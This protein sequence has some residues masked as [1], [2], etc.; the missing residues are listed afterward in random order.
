[1]KSYNTTE[2]A[3]FMRLTKYCQRNGRLGCTVL[4]RTEETSN[5]HTEQDLCGDVMTIRLGVRDS[6][7]V[8]YGVQN[9]V[10]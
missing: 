3:Q 6:E 1:M 10:K 8:D 7:D 4:S 2:A 9:H 5:V